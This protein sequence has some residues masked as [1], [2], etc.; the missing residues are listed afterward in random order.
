MAPTDKG[1]SEPDHSPIDPER[2]D[3]QHQRCQ[4]R[5]TKISAILLVVFGANTY[6]CSSVLILAAKHLPNLRANCF[7]VF[8]W[9]IHYTKILGS[10]FYSSQ[11]LVRTEICGTRS[12]WEKGMAD[13]FLGSSHF[14]DHWAHNFGAVQAWMQ[15]VDV[16]HLKSPE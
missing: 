2:N 1:P 15:A 9:S 11:L 7:D 6:M 13:E 10:V 4:R 5:S 8:D 14:D 12:A 3:I 16:G